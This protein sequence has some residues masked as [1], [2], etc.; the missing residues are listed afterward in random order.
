MLLLLFRFAVFGHVHE[1][2]GQEDDTTQQITYIN[3]ASVDKDFN[4]CNKPIVCY[5]IVSICSN[6]QQMRGWSAHPKTVSSCMSNEHLPQ[7][8]VELVAF[9]E[10]L[11]MEP[12]W[13]TQMAAPR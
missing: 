11:V 3:A 4:P 7:L 1:S 13:P 8:W 6:S 5:T 2:Y 12:Q 9:P 10:A